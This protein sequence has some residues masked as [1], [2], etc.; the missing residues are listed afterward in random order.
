MKN[1]IVLTGA[2]ISAESG[3]S[4]FRDAGGLWEGY[5]IMEVA[6][7]EGW[8]KNPK[9]VL[10]FYNIRRANMVKAQPN[11]AHLIVAELQKKYN[12]TVITQ[13]VDDLHERAGSKNIIHLH[14][15][16][17]KSRSTTNP[18]LI[19][20][21]TGAE[22]N[23]GDCCEI[24]SQLRPNIVWFGEDVPMMPLA[25]NIVSMSDCLIIIG[26]SMIVYP[27]ANLIH[28]VQ[29]GIK[30]FYIDPNVPDFKFDNNVIHIK[31]KAT[32]G[33]E[34]LTTKYLKL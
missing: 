2:G 17:K 11:K 10:D 7:I 12:V 5:D 16:L 22:L 19:Y 15:E 4:T 23:I 18:E 27:A 3:I 13:N 25:A 20:E 9:L 32:I 14:G 6:S 8:Q 21:I 30:V 24:G 34:I 26:T 28:Y 33:M 31:E 29:K 1:V